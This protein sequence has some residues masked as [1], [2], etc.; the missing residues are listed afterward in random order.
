MRTS[1]SAP[2]A[3]S[4]SSTSTASWWYTRTLPAFVVGQRVQQAADAG[5]CTSMP[6]KSREGPAARQS[7]A[8][9]VAEADFQH[10]GRGA[11]ERRPGRAAPV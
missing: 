9:A 10:L 11:A 3:I 1:S 2:S 5:A 7:A 6:M 4:F 8:L